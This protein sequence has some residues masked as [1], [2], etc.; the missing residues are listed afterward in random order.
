MFITFFVHL[1]N[2]I[3][4]LSLFILLM[5]KKKKETCDINS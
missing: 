1:F 4:A 5:F 2:E 3:I